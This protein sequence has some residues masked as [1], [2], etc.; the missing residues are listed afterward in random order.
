MIGDSVLNGGNPT[1]QSQ[2]LSERFKAKLS[3]FQDSTQVLNASAGSWGIGN[4]LGYLR[5]FGTFQVDAII[6]QIGT[7]DLI[8]PTSTSERVGRDPNYPNQPPFFAFQEVVSRYAIPKTT[9]LLK[10]N[11]SSTEIPKVASNQ[12][13]LQFEQN[14]EKLR[15]I[16]SLT[17]AEDIPVFVLYTPSRKDLLPTFNS[18]PYKSEF[19][20]LLNSLE[21]PVIDTHANWS[22]LPKDTVENYFRDKVHLNETGNQAVAELLFQQ[23]CIERQLS[24]CQQ[25]I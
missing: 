16:I 19:F 15:N 8:Q 13:K 7:H 18:P 21:I 22:S 3:T 14:M 5:K 23:L 20:Q 17:H 12:Q 10:R 2:I 4:Q 25:K 9:R 11:S 24:V 6:L 1:D